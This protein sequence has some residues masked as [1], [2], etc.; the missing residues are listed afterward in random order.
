MLICC[1]YSE[2]SRPEVDQFYS[3]EPESPTIDRGGEKLYQNN[4]TVNTKLSSPP[5]MSD[6][7]SQSIDNNNKNLGV[8]THGNCANTKNSVGTE[9]EEPFNYVDDYYAKDSL[10]KTQKVTGN[11]DRVVGIHKPSNEKVKVHRQMSDTTSSRGRVQ[12]S[13]T[14]DI[15]KDTARRQL[16]DSEGGRVKVSG[17]S[18]ETEGDNGLQSGGSQQHVVMTGNTDV[19]LGLAHYEAVQVRTISDG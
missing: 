16:S 6:N 13:H 3:N 11:S 7:P 12:T 1:R 5:N 15:R 2:D 17:P 14:S 18:L 9:N 19:V 10:S 4:N 8:S